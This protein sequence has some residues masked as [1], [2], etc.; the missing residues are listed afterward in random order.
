MP[1]NKLRGNV[2]IGWTCKE[3]FPLIKDMV[4]YKPT[5]LGVMRGSALGHICL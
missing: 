4:I 2:C 5:F 1:F 3:L